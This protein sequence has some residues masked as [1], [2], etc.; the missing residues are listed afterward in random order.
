[1]RFSIYI[2]DMTSDELATVS[3]FVTSMGGKQTNPKTRQTVAELAAAT[4]A[5]G[6]PQAPAGDPFAAAANVQHQNAAPATPQTQTPPPPPPPPPGAGVEVDSRGIPHNPQFH[7]DS[8][9]KNNDGSWAKRKGVD[10]DACEAWEGSFAGNAPQ[11]PPPPPPP[12]QAAQAPQTPPPPPGT[13][14]TAAETTAKFAPHLAGMPN[15]AASPDPFAAPNPEPAAVTPPPPPPPPAP[16]EQEIPSVDYAEWHR[17]YMSLY[18]TGRLT[19][20]K[21]T[22]I[23]DPLGGI[24]DQMKFFNDEVARGKCYAEFLKLTSA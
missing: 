18:T 13:T 22:E 11:T 4:G 7:A 8:K 23:A 1:M 20:E 6:V 9:R 14:L 15:G 5:G 19:P 21:Y 10:K 3:N 17:M 24:E 16:V 2:E 12:V